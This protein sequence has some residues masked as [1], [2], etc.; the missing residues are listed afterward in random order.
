VS[1]SLLGIVLQKW[2]LPEVVAYLKER[3]AKGLPP[4]TAAQIG[5]RLDAKAKKK[6]AQGLAFLDSKT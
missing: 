6:L 3:H 1:A 4:P 5:R 2:I